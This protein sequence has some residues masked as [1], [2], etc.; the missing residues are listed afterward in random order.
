MVNNGFSSTG[1]L[2][3][4]RN[5]IAQPHILSNLMF[6]FFY[7][8]ENPSMDIRDL[9]LTY[10]RLRGAPFLSSKYNLVKNVKLQVK[11]WCFNGGN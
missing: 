8:K 9:V 1:N 3:E 6:S 2:F 7:L 10:Q 11:S 5:K 4:G